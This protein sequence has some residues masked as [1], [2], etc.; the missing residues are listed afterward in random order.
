V[1]GGEYVSRNGALRVA[2]DQFQVQF[3]HRW[4]SLRDPHVRAL[5]GLLT[6]PNLLDH[7]FPAWSDKLV[8]L[9]EIDDATEQWLKQLDRTPDALHTLI[10]TQPSARLGR[11]AEKLLGFYLMHTG[12]LVAQNLQVRDGPKKTIGEFDF[13]IRHDAL[14]GLEHWEFATK[15]YL[16]EAASHAPT[17]QSY[18]GPNLADSFGLKINKVMQQQ[19]CLATHP[20]A[21]SYLP[22]TV[23]SAK[24]L[25][26]GCLFYHRDHREVPS[27]LGL[28][29]D[30]WQGFWVDFADLLLD[31]SQRYVVLSRLSW[32]APIALPIDA[33]LTADQLPAAILEQFAWSSVPI[34]IAV[35]HLEDGLALEASRGFVVPEDW[36][37]Q[38]LAKVQGGES[39]V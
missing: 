7:H 26:K 27:T 31:R 33:T 13:L 12:Q 35:C 30:H 16:L 34:M 23:Q 24:A 3:H 17:L 1:F 9:G 38:A 37:Q 20:A 36:H 5:A 15:F 32:L 10:N 8:V 25:L 2:F 6:M 19:L 29:P 22:Q 11:Y 18:V 14:S 28:A 21:Q 39:N 4:G